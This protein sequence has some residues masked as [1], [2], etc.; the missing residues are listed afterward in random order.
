MDISTIGFE[1]LGVG[2]MAVYFLLPVFL[3]AHALRRIHR[4]EKEFGV[5]PPDARRRRGWPTSGAAASALVFT[6]LVPLCWFA[7]DPHWA[8]TAGSIG[9]SAFASWGVKRGSSRLVLAAWIGSSVHYWIWDLVA[10]WP[11][12]SPWALGGVAWFMIGLAFSVCALP[13]ICG[14]FLAKAHAVQALLIINS[15]SGWQGL[16]LG[17]FGAVGGAIAVALTAHRPEGS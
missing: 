7:F 15:L 14:R 12:M 3:A 11:P 8:M 17:L 2:L 13:G 1:V 16:E 6:G 10:F 5:P 9:G 4:V